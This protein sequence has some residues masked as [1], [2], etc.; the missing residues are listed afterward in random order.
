[1]DLPPI[2]RLKKEFFDTKL[3]RSLHL[4]IL[5]V[6]RIFHAEEPSNKQK[7]NSHCIKDSDDLLQ[8][9]CRGETQ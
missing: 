6:L 5:Q 8:R 3:L 7:V 1:M 4:H 2:L 9:Y